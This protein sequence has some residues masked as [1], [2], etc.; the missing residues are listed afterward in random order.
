MSEKFFVTK[1]PSLCYTR[2]SPREGIF[3]FFTISFGYLKESSYLC[4]Q[5]TRCINIEQM[6][7]LKI[8]N[9]NRT[10]SMNK[11]VYKS[12]LLGTVGLA[13]M[14]ASC[15]SNSENS[16]PENSSEAL[17]LQSKL[18]GTSW[19]MVLNHCVYSSGT[20]SDYR[21]DGV[22][23]FGYDG[24]LYIN[25]FYPGKY[26]YNC[27]GEWYVKGKDE[28]RMI[29]IK[30]DDGDG[31][32]PE[33]T[34]MLIDAGFYRDKV[35]SLTDNSMRLTMS[36]YEGDGYVDFVKV[37]YQDGN[38]KGGGN[39]GGG[40]G[41]SSGDIPYITSFTFD[42]TKTSITVKFMC[43]ER[44]TSAIVKYGTSSASSTISSSI[45]GKQVSATVTNL[46]AGTKYYFNCTVRDDYG[47]STSD[48]FS[49]ITNY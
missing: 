5:E 10:R 28:I 23:T 3:L 26:Y 33:I 43:S 2:L 15:S 37:P 11:K 14:M 34:A 24:K 39:S 12:L 45:S 21:R 47:S 22:M 48:T 35:I 7:N 40:G 36:Y 30:C 17:E 20:V 46:K 42:A 1:E 41:S 31:Y 13:L 27:A 4:T 8:T 44:P 29:N 25:N 19:E 32:G 38:Y 18:E 49:A 9:T 6:F 16:D